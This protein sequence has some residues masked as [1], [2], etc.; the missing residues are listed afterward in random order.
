MRLLSALRSSKAPGSQTLFLGNIRHAI[1]HTS[2]PKNQDTQCNHRAKD[3]GGNMLRKA[4]FVVIE[5][6]YHNA[7]AGQEIRHLPI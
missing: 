5:Q 2:C 3:R 6:N 4:D 1:N 7:D